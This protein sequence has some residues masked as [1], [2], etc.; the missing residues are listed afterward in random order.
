MNIERL[1]LRLRHAMSG[2]ERASALDGIE[3]LHLIAAMVCI[4]LAL[5]VARFAHSST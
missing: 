3:D 2:W 5:L 4:V 1:K